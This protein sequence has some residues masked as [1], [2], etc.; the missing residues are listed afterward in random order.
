MT[1]GRKKRMFGNDD[2]SELEFSEAVLVSDIRRRVYNAEGHLNDP[3]AHFL[4][5]S[6]AYRLCKSTYSSSEMTRLSENNRLSSSSSS[7]S[8][9][10]SPV[11]FTQQATTQQSS[12]Q[13]NFHDSAEDPGD[14]AF[15]TERRYGGVPARDAA[16]VIQRA[17]RRYSMVKEFQRIKTERRLSRRINNNVVGTS[18]SPPVNSCDICIEVHPEGGHNHHHNNHHHDLNL[19]GLEE[20]LEGPHEL[21]H[22]TEV[23]VQ[24]M[25]SSHHS[26]HQSHSNLPPQYHYLHQHNGGYRQTSRQQPPQYNHPPNAY[27]NQQQLQQQN[28]RQ[29]Q[30]QSQHH[31]HHPHYLPHQHSESSV[32]VTSTSSR[33]QRQKP[34]HIPQSHS[35]SQLLPHQHSL[36]YSPNSAPG[37]LM[38]KTTTI[39]AVSSHS[40]SSPNVNGTTTS[41]SSESTNTTPLTN[42]SPNLS[43]GSSTGK[44]A[45]S[46][47]ESEIL[48]KRLYRVGLNLFNK[49]PEVG[50][51]YLVK[52]KFLEGSP[53]S[54]ARFLV[55]RKGLSKQMIGEYLTNLQ[56]P[57]SM[58]CLEHF[59]NEIDLSS[60]PVDL[61]LRKF[62]C[63]YR[64]PGEAQKIERLMESFSRRY[65]ACNPH[66][67][68][69]F[70]NCADTVFVLA[71]A[72]IMLNTDLHTPHLK[73]DRRMK[74]DDFIKN[75]RSVDDGGDIDREILVGIYDRIKATEFKTGSDHVTQ[76]MKVQQTIVGKKP[77]LAVPH[78]RLV[79]YCRLYEVPDTNKKEKAGTHQREVFLFNDLLVLTKIFHKKR[80]SVTYSFRQSYPLQGLTLSLFSNQYFEYGLA[81]KRGEQTLLNLNAR[82]EHDRA[83]FTEDLREAIA[84]SDE[85]TR[86][87]TISKEN[88]DRDSGVD[89][90]KIKRFSNSLLDINDQSLRCLG[91]PVRRGSCGSL[92]SGMS[93]SFQSDE[94]HHPH[95]A[96]HIISQPPVLQ[97]SSSTVSSTTSSSS[98]SASQHCHH[99]PKQ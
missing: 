7:S 46:T 23:E 48:R 90:G 11:L 56:S 32:V 45:L 18:S 4:C 25:V 98:P 53:P 82:N 52:K 78:R 33:L 38:V 12:S 36:Q 28:N 54:V 58:S 1:K 65:A 80:N 40:N 26:T 83:K 9:S 42:V 59:V 72:I 97:G 21:P 31:H 6:R 67:V 44:T 91:K 61:A 77:N 86:I 24:M 20:G 89:V 22:V 64:M 13:P 75:L 43:T 8:A 29:F 15:V 70:R 85:M 79:C 47:E 49:K 27:N 50:V 84:E 16:L 30:S 2:E 19:D 87:E 62:Q 55:S 95:H 37:L 3:F 39:A 88:R 60:L 57:F 5:R 17:Y 96:P 35:G 41:S 94:N 99:P 73:A 10:S 74:V 81:L 66:V 92:D 14:S 51:T 34:H 63:Y 69:Q 71:F 76:V 68:S 93:V